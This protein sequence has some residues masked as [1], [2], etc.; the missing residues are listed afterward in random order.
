MQPLFNQNLSVGGDDANGM[1]HFNMPL[2]GHG[3]E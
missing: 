3:N 2:P 1:D